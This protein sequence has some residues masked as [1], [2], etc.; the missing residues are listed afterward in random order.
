[1]SWNVRTG[2]AFPLL[3]CTTGPGG[4]AG[5]FGAS[6]RFAGTVFT[7]SSSL[8]SHSTA[9]PIAALSCRPFTSH[10][11]PFATRPTHRL[12]RCGMVIV[13]AKFLPSGDQIGDENLNRSSSPN[14]TAFGSPPSILRKA[15]PTTRGARA[16]PFVC[17]LIRSPA[18]RSIGSATSA[19]DG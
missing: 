13:M 12:I 5:G 19:M 7:N 2:A 17:G 4:A 6:P 15:M 3:S 1:M 11:A 18:S 8:L 10:A 14:F 16:G 9:D